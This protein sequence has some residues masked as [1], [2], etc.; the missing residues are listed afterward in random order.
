M[1]FGSERRENDLSRLKITL[2]SDL[3]S[4][5][6]DGFS[7]LIDTDVSYDKFGFP[8]IG[9]RRLKGCLREAAEL[10]G[11]PYIDEIFGVIGKA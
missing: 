3:C 2:K 6:G 5:S 7:S 4:A 1:I 10:I 11:S 9:G 8:Y